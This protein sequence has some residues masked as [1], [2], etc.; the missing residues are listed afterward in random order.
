MW[1]NVPAQM[2]GALANAAVNLYVCFATVLLFFDLR[3][4]REGEDIEA[5]LNAV[6]GGK[7]YAIRRV[8][9]SGTVSPR[10]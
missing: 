3:R 1:L 2:L 6:A 10:E 9:E 8:M 4:R 7:S 5:E